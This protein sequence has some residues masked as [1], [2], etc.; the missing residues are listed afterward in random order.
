MKYVRKYVSSCAV[1]ALFCFTYSSYSYGMEKKS[2]SEAEM[3]KWILTHAL[4]SPVSPNNQEV[5]KKTQQSNGIIKTFYSDGTFKMT[6]SRSALE[7]F[8]E[9][10]VG[11]I[12]PSK[13]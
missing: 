7:K 3:H 13:K 12:P 5:V 9:S 1:M 8:A 11:K 2:S 10:H 4:L 6:M